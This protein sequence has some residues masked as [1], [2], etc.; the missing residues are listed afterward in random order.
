MV[1]QSVWT[2]KS[3]MIYFNVGVEGSNNVCIHISVYE[4][5]FMGNEGR[6]QKARTDEL[7]LIRIDWEKFM[8][9]KCHQVTRSLMD[10]VYMHSP[11]G[12]LG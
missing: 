11:S 12:F 1:K 8:F 2:N 9:I 5:S 10:N 6:R 7:Q 3:F 4:I